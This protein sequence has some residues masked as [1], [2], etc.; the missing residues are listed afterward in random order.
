[1]PADVFRMLIC[2]PSN[3][4]KVNSLLHMIYELLVF[5]K[6]IS[7]QKTSTKTNIRLFCKTLPQILTLS[8]VTWLLTRW[9]MKFFHVKSCRWTTIQSPSLMIWFV[10]ATRTV[11]SA[12]LSTGGIENSA[13][14]ISLRPTKSCLNTS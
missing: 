10:N 4:G 6:I 3:S 5:D 2:G 14:S 9:E 7:F 1:M 12:I 13:S 11:S 8:L